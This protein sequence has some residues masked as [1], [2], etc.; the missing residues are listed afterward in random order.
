MFKFL[1]YLL[2]IFLFSDDEQK[3]IRK[4]KIIIN[5]LRRHGSLPPEDTY[6]V[7]ETEI[8]NAYSHKILSQSAES[9]KLQFPGLTEEEI[10]TLS[11]I[12]SEENSE[13]SNC[14]NPTVPHTWE[15]SM[16]TLEDLIGGM[17][18][19]DKIVMLEMNN[20]YENSSFLSNTQTKLKNLP[21]NP[22]EVFNVADGFVRRI[23]KVAKQLEFFRTIDKED[24]IALLKGSVVEIMMLRS[25]VNFNVK[26]ETW[27]LNTSSCIVKTGS[28]SSEAS[29]EAS[30]PSACPNLGSQQN[31]SMPKPNMDIES[32]RKM[33]KGGM[34]LS[35]VIPGLPPNMNLDQLRDLGAK[36]GFCP[37]ASEAKKTEESPEPSSAST[38]SAEI[39]KMGNSETRNM[40][41]TYS[42][43]IKSLMTTIQ[44]D[45]VILKFLIMMSLFSPDRPGVVDRTSIEKYQEVYANVL[46]KYINL[47]FPAT[48][49]MFARCVM[50]LTDLRNINEVH[51][52]MLLK[53]QLDNI[54]PLLIEIFDLSS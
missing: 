15:E 31:I 50:K 48:K 11:K 13:N 42:K 33:A 17:I 6:S 45:L 21:S 47:R 3:K 41:L 16:D 2:Y 30:S 12:K 25:A 49:N 46:Q 18:E 28:S 43:F 19:A 32:L 24:Q 53:M 35:K 37:P 52:K 5:K 10:Q 4:Q 38:I 26:T 44:G 20:A 23:I 22:T 1:E 40:F 54:E 9:L 7:S 39:L 34:D 14:S 8:R 27:T 29:S 51:T 36:F